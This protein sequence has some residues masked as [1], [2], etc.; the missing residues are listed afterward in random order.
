MG[1]GNVAPFE[2][3]KL[4]VIVEPTSDV[5]WMSDYAGPTFVEPRGDT[6]RLYVTGRDA[7]G[8]S[9][10]GIVDGSLVEDRFEIVGIQAEPVLD[11][12]E[13]GMF[14]ESGASYPWLVQHGD[15]VFMYFVGWTA[16]TKTR[17]RN[18]LGLAISSNGGASFERCSRIPILD[19]TETEPYGSGSCAVWTDHEGWHMLYTAF[20]PWWQGAGRQSPSY[21]L[22]EARSED[23]IVWERTQRVVLDFESDDEY[24]IGKPMIVFD[25]DC[26]RLWYCYRGENYLIGYAE[27]TD[28]RNFTRRD[29]IVGIDVSGTGWDSEMVE[30]AFIFDHGGERYMVYNGN[31]FGQTGLGLA[32]S[33]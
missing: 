10:I 19:R 22:K 25:D 14:D 24:V 21:R 12:G 2:W 15:R 27:S 28:G 18:F 3:T 5:A 32:V 1:T 33:A 26:T 30:Y 4:G 17:F 7:H 13:V 23:G 9:R 31:Q 6:V 20:E 11:L 16:G 8:Q 29:D